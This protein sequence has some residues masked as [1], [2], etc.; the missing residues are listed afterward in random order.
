MAVTKTERDRPAI[1]EIKP[2]SD[3]IDAGAEALRLALGVG[4]QPK[5]F[6]RQPAEEAFLAMIRL[7]S[8]ASVDGAPESL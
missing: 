2:S 5:Y 7:A 4:G 6:F 3:M 1:N 8:H